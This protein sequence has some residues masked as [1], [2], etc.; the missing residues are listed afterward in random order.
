MKCL[1]GRSDGLLSPRSLTRSHV[2]RT[3][4]PSGVDGPGALGRGGAQRTHAQGSL[5]PRSRVWR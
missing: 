4:G 2:S 3:V 1:Q 5:D